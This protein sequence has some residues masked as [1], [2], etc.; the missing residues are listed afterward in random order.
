MKSVNQVTI[1]KFLGGLTVVG[2]IVGINLLFVAIVA[3]SFYVSAGAPKALIAHF[4]IG[5]NR[6]CTGIP[7]LGHYRG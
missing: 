6:L 1:E 7:L 5:T 3:P 2:I 4:C